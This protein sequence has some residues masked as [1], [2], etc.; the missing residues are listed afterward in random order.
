MEGLIVMMYMFLSL[1]VSH[2]AA[3]LT[4]RAVQV[5]EKVL[6]SLFWFVILQGVVLILGEFVRSAN[7]LNSPWG[8]RLAVVVAGVFISTLT[9]VREHLNKKAEAAQQSAPSATSQESTV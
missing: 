1:A 9:A 4:L 7:D 6:A 8:F 2:V 3:E 5:V